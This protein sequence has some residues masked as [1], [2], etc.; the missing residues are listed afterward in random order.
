MLDKSE[1]SRVSSADVG[2]GLSPSQLQIVFPYHIA[3]DANFQIIQL[4]NKLMDMVIY[5]LLV[6]KHISD[7]FDLIK[8]NGFDWDWNHM[9]I[10]QETSFELDLKASKT[11]KRKEL[12][13]ISL[14][15]DI[16]LQGFDSQ[17]LSTKNCIQS[18]V[19]QSMPNGAILLLH[20]NMST[21]EE[22]N[23]NGY[24]MSDVS[25]FDMQADLFHVGKFE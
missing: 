23:D 14:R 19:S 4:G 8:P 20:L 2:V 22:L 24:R 11:L 16:L 10:N 9:I 21:T 6:G 5:Q 25:K 18:T 12:K 17:L 7:S 15:G 1:C 13:K 3:I